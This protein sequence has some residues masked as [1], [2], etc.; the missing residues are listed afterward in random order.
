M[1]ATLRTAINAGDRRLVT[2]SRRFGD[3]F[4]LIRLRTGISQ[5]AIARAIGVD[6]ATICRL[7]AGDGAVSNAVRARAAA[8]LGADFGLSLFPAASPLIHDAAH[9]RL[10][11]RLIGNRHPTWTVT[12]EAPVPA[13]G[14]RSSDI[15]L[16]RGRDIVLIEVEPRVHALEALIREAHEKRALVDAAAPDRRVHAVLLLPPTRHNRQVVRDHPATIRA[17]FPAGSNGMTQ[18][19]PRTVDALAGRRHLLAWGQRSRRRAEPD[20][21]RGLI[22]AISRAAARDGGRG[23]R[24]CGVGKLCGAW[25]VG[26]ARRLREPMRPPFD[27]LTCD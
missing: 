7:E 19:A 26:F 20:P 13:G 25:A 2:T 11:D 3:E 4:R 15:R 16:D 12:L 1:A 24:P 22:D 21:A 8:V 14:R 27:R 6:R 9:A 10:V 18:V 5:A 23:G 17:A